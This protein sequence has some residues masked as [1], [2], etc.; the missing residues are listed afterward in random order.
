[1][2]DAGVD[3]R[4]RYDRQLRIWGEQGQSRLESARVCLLHCG[5]TGTEA[6]K[7]LVLGGIAGFT[8]VDGGKVT[9]A[10]LGNKC[11]ARAARVCACDA[12]RRRRLLPLLTTACARPACSFLVQASALGTPRAACVAALLKELNDAVAGAYVE[13]EPA[14]LLASDPAFFK[15]F[16]LVIATQA[17]DSPTRRARS[18]AVP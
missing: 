4:R 2:A 18:A 8:L 12:G 3:K 16:T 14:Q 17:R 11:V 13:E 7:N 9:A 15:D 1:M 10:D 5:P 6:L